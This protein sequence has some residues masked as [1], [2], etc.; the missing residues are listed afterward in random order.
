MDDAGIQSFETRANVCVK[1]EPSPDGM[2]LH[3][4]KCRKLQDR[5]QGCLDFGRHLLSRESLRHVELSHDFTREENLAEFFKKTVGDLKNKIDRKYQDY[6]DAVQLQREI[7]LKKLEHDSERKL[8]ALLHSAG[9]LNKV[10]EYFR[11]SIKSSS[12]DLND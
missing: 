2:E 10:N 5:V 7:E 1:T 4:R 9:V 6:I 11:R 12:S 3:Q 8:T